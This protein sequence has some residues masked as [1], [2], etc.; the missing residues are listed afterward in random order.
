MQWI[1]LEQL[2]EPW[3]F[4][5][6]WKRQ[7]CWTR[8][9]PVRLPKLPCEVMHV[10]DF[11]SQWGVYGYT[12]FDKFMFQFSRLLLV[13]L[14]HEMA[15]IF[16]TD[17]EGLIKGFSSSN[18]RVL[19]SMEAVQKILVQKVEIL[20]SAFC[21]QS[22]IL[23]QLRGL[24]H[25]GCFS[26]STLY[27]RDASWGRIAQDAHCPICRVQNSVNLGYEGNHTHTLFVWEFHET[28]LIPW[29]R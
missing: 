19:R 24:D 10:W 18:E 7:G 21:H 9:Q 3:G 1:W 17:T 16:R 13:L 26:G 14:F 12:K 27:R 2:E 20:D 23:K 4:P 5:R 15:W 8:S 11:F 29:G 28:V 22:T 25:V 6:P